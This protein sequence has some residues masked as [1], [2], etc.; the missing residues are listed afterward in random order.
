MVRLS[1]LGDIEQ[2]FATRGGLNY[3]EGVTQTE[4][5]LQCASLAAADGA[6]PSLIAAALLHDI[7][8]LFEGEAAALAF[9]GRH[10]I[11]GAQA[12][13][14]LFG[15]DVVRPIALHV[16]AKRYLCCQEPGYFE[17]LS[18]ASRRTLELQGGPFSGS[19]AA[20]FDR[21]PYCR[22]ALA[23]RR[24]DEMGKRPEPSGRRLA[25]FAPLLRELVIRSGRQPSQ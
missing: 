15:E 16:A 8:H 13:K 25:D 18:A 21:Q 4:H 9:D 6:P 3:G 2:L 5:A 12:L 7:G 17:T 20:A 11:T 19:Q 10:E 1:S 14:A 23:L 22:E 24:Y